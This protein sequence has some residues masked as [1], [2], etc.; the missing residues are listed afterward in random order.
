MMGVMLRR[1]GWGMRRTTLFSLIVTAFLLLGLQVASADVQLISGETQQIGNTLTSGK[2][3]YNVYYSYPSTAN[4]GTNL[5]VD[6]TLHLNFFTGQVEYIY[7]YQLETQLFINGNEL[8]HAVF[9]PAGFN[10]SSFLYPGANWGPLNFTFPLT[11]NNTGV[12]IGQ[13][14]NATLLVTLRDTV[15]YGVPV[16]G[17]QTEPAMQASA[18]SLVIQ[19]P[20]ATSTSTSASGST[21]EQAGGGG[22][23][24]SYALLA[25]GAVLM[26]AAVILPRGPK[27]I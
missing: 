16:N 20:I 10:Q 24:L 18:G 25:S 17:Y 2:T 13:T 22:S 8:D 4:V 1:E 27:P 3:S 21:T 14:Q 7:G 6:L 26:V 15:F 9:G 23:L 19:N 11:E 5:T 12:A